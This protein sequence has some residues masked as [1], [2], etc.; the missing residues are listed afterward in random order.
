[1]TIALFISVWTED[2]DASDLRGDF[3]ERALDFLRARPAV[4]SV[5]LYQPEGGDV[6]RF[7]DLAPPRLIV[8]IDVDHPADAN[9]L[10]GSETFQGLLLDR[11]AYRAA[12]K[13][14]GLDILET[15]HF[16]LPGQPSPPPRTAPLSFVVRYYGPTGNGAA[17]AQFYT[18]HHPLLLATFPGI[19]NVLCYLPLDWRSSGEVTD[20][21]VI[22]GN[23]VVFDDLE[24][25]NRALAS[26]VL[27]KLRA[28]G[29][30]FASFGYSTH[31]A[32]RRERVY[33]RDDG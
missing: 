20:S 27:P 9:S 3:L 19:R 30:Q 11:S 8:Q 14:L 25:L 18:D 5:E 15:V 26:D 22:L 1:M 16:P 21:R 29:K 2:S 23:E 4:R 13:E 7:E 33:A 17:F 32:M 24:A 31:H 10:A 12:V 28:E 6:P